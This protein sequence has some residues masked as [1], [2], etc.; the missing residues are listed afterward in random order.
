M[1][2]SC[3]F[4]CPGVSLLFP[5][6]NST[7]YIIF[8]KKVLKYLL[9]EFYKYIVHS[10]TENFYYKMLDLEGTIDIF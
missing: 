1:C 3:L 10:I 9:N 8:C 7:E 4:L 5:F 2:I 6:A